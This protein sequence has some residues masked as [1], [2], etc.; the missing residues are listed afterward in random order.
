MTKK[1]WVITP[2]DMT[3]ATSSGWE[4]LGNN[5]YRAVRAH[6][7]VDKYREDFSKTGPVVHEQVLPA[8]SEF[9]IEQKQ[10]IVRKNISTFSSSIHRAVSTK[11]S[12]EVA[13]KIGSELSFSAKGPAGKTGSE[14]S[15]KF[16]TEFTE[17]LSRDFSSVKSFEIESTEEFVRSLVLKVPEQGTAEMSKYFFYLPLWVWRWDLYL[18]KIE[19]VELTYRKTWYLKQIRESVHPVSYDVKIPLAQIMFYEPLDAPS[20]VPGVY[21]PEVKD[22]SEVLIRPVPGVCPVAINEDAMALESFVPIA[23]PENKVERAQSRRAGALVA[24]TKKTP[25]SRVIERLETA[26]SASKAGG[27]KGAGKQLAKNMRHDG[28]IISKDNRK[29]GKGGAGKGQSRATIKDGS[30]VRVTSKG[31]G[32]GGAKQTRVQ[33]STAKGRAGAS[34]ARSKLGKG[35]SGTKGTSKG[36]GRKK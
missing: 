13:A 33:M 15:T 14:V 21:V 10:I 3:L 8:G 1:D 16:G 18:Y 25:A 34:E 11:I 31:S 27:R 29:I 19:I 24:S 12:A 7:L 9:K 32:K 26:S 17:S 5:R 23:F 28:R 35:Q 6:I 30:S 22:A 4:S 20:V 2:D 36:G